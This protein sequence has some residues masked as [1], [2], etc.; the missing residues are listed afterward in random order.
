MWKESLL[1]V[2]SLVAFKEICDG[3]HI[4]EGL[5][6]D[7]V[8][9]HWKD[10]DEGGSMSSVDP[11]AC[12]T[13][14]T[15]ADWKARPPKARL[16]MDTPAAFVV[17]HHTNMAECFTYDECCKMMRSIQDF[18]MDV[19]EW[20]DI[21]YSFLVGEDGLV[22]EGRGWDTVGSHAPW[23]NFRSLGVSIM[24]DFTTKIPNQKAVDAVNYIINCAITN[25]KLDPDY[26]LI[27]HRQAT[28]N[29][30]CPGELALFK[31][32]QSWP[33]WKPGDHFPPKH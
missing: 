13:I 33:H 22:Y 30:T 29:R 28:P 11:K 16:D 7:H 21:A 1:V 24:G 17:L 27:S 10:I 12:P 32:I 15:R 25:K 19:R 2:L 23:Y 26:V 5:Q 20:D 6:N 9:N 18:H 4:I 31:G 8:H 3:V 14:V